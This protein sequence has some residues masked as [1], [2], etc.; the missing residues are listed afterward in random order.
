M[1]LRCL[2]WKQGFLGIQSKVTLREKCVLSEER[3]GRLRKEWVKDQPALPYLLNRDTNHLGPEAAPKLQPGVKR[4]EPFFPKCFPE[5]CLLSGSP[6]MPTVGFQA[7]ANSNEILL[8]LLFSTNNLEA[9][10][11]WHQDFLTANNTT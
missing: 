7:L 2:E 8:L 10:R 6:H 11:R 5:W 9:L 3:E 1:I 4:F